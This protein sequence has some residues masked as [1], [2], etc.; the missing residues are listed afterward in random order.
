MNSNEY[1]TCI[2][3][4]TAEKCINIINIPA[5][6]H[7]RKR[8]KGRNLTQFYDKIPYTNKKTQK[9]QQKI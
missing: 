3:K 4:S 8:E 6:V 7:G 5:L 9:G 2:H 1:L